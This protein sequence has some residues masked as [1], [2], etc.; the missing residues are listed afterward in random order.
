MKLV[1]CEGKDEIAVIAELCKARSIDGLALEHY[2]GIPNVWNVMEQLPKRPAYAQREIK[3]LA[4]LMDGDDNPEGAWQRLCD[5]ARQHLAASLPGR[6][7]FAGQ[8]PR[9]AGYIIAGTDGNGMLEDLCL[10]AIN[11]KPGF[12]CLGDFF[13]CMAEQTEKKEYHA[14]A[15]FR[16]WMSTQSDYDLG[17]G[18]AATRGHLPWDS[19]AFDHLVTFLKTV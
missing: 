3:S 14:K 6:G 18:L 8:Q 5:M 15:R 12:G 17:V 11:G 4:I 2:G 10:Q 13:R 9:V 1:L 19:P 7:A 16:A